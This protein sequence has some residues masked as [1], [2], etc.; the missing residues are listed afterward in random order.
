M[1]IDPQNLLILFHAVQLPDWHRMLSPQNLLFGIQFIIVFI[2]VLWLYF[3]IQ[4]TYIAQLLKGVA[5]ILLLYF[6]AGLLNLTVIF[7]ILQ[8]FLQIIIIGFIIL[9]QPELRRLLVYLGQPDL[10]TRQAFAGGGKEK[11]SKHLVHELV[12]S[13]R[14]LS[15]NKIG[16]LIV[17]ESNNI[18]AGGIYL[19]AG[20]HLDA[21]LST[22]LLL[23]IFHPNTP[24]HDGAVIISPDNRVVAAGVLLP[25]SEN[26]NLSWKYGTR[27]RAAIGLSEVSDNR[28]LVVSE[29][30][31][32]ISIAYNGNI[33][34]VASIEDLTH[35]LEHLYGIHGAGEV[36]GKRLPLMD[37][38][39][40]DIFQKFFS[41]G[42]PKKQEPKKVHS[43]E[44]KAKIIPENTY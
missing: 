44:E 18:A 21:R 11:N 39:S 33:E 9:F 20:T 41:K 1:D 42:T 15:K 29:E 13:I 28:C 17:L 4:G 22:E 19:E 35:Q 31:G 36:E 40:T 24:L 32:H 5:V 12:E 38:L 3:K 30:T 7:N 10:F 25:L 27:H 34:R 2:A 14:L 16:A 37:M 43:A 23:T 26:P 6:V 8:V